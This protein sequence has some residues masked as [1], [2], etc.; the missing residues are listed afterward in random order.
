MNQDPARNRFIV[1]QAL[2]LG[3]VVMVLLSLLA[4]NGVLPI[5]EIAAWPILVIGLVDIFVVPQ[6][7]ARKWRTPLP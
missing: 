4:L 5:P 7:L 2:R 6:I 3:G 1:M